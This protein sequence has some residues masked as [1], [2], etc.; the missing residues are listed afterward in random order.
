MRLAV[1]VSALRRS[2][3]PA[4][5]AADCGPDKLGTSRIVEVGTEGGL[6]VGFKTY[7]KA[8][9]ARRSRGDP[10]LRRRARSGDDAASA[11]GARRRMRAR[12]LFR[13]SAAKSRRR[14]SL[15]GARPPRGTT[16]PITP[17]PIPQPTLR[18]MGDRQARADIL[19]GMI[20]V[21]KV[22]YGAGFQRRRA[23]GPRAASSCTRRS[24]AFPA[25]PTRRT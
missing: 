13:L 12:H 16:S 2:A 21:E 8:D 7:P 9:S 11:R 19:R 15:R 14:P 24:S 10:D 22:A 23:E 5:A 25:S 17:T 6:A 3:S 20:A 1:V 18:Y 4:P